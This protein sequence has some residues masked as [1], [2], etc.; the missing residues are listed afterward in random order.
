MRHANRQE[1]TG[2]RTRS[3]RIGAAVIGLFSVAL[4]LLGSSNQADAQQTNVVVYS[5]SNFSGDSWSV[6]VGVYPFAAIN[7]SPVGNDRISSIS[8]PNGY[9]VFACQHSNRGGT[10]ETYQNSVVQLT[11][12]NNEISHFEVGIADQPATTGSW[13]GV[14]GTP[15]VPVAASALPNGKVLMW[16][17]FDRYEFGGA[18]GYTQTSLFNPATNS[19]TLRQ[20]SNTGHDMFC[21]GITNLP[22]GRIL[23]N[24]GDNASE[25]TIY[26]PA[27]DSWNNADDMTSPAATTQPRC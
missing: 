4:L 6:G 24:G 26:D 15:L 14:I 5:G 11:T 19:S 7:G 25:T 22:D 17:A 18:R 13:S 2:G 20:V 9:E 10:C 1:A 21:P 16:S 23:I 3:A 12:L 8:I 27:N